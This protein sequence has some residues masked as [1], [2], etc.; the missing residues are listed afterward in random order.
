[1]RGTACCDVRVRGTACSWCCPTA[2]VVV[3]CLRELRYL[4]FTLRDVSVPVLCAVAWLPRGCLCAVCAVIDCL[5]AVCAVI[6]WTVREATAEK[7]K[8]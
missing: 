7:L 8:L 4:L 2:A 1:M 5:C 3:L 6:D